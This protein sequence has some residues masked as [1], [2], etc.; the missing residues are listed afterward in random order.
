MGVQFEPSGSPPSP[1][2]R[3]HWYAY[4][5]GVAPAHVPRLAKRVRP[6]A[7]VPLIDGSTVFR[8]GPVVV[9]CETVSVGF[10][11][12]VTEPTALVAVTWT[13]SRLP[14]SLVVSV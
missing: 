13:R 8:G 12:T 4:E 2:Q 1:P 14:I 5:S 9:A 11:A 3:T 7:S 10:E 6:R